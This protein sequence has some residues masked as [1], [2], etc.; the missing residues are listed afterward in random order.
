MRVPARASAALRAGRPRSRGANVLSR[1]PVIPAKAG[2]Q[3]ISAKLAIRNQAPIAANGSLL[4][5][6]EKARM[7]VPA[8]AS[9]ALRAGRPRSQ[10]ANV[11]SRKPVIPAKAGIQ[12]ISAK[13][14]I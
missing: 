9:A 8:R 11:L 7:R 13:L 5:L 10:G 3:S 4:P 6:R 12:S 1:K 14:A 2:I